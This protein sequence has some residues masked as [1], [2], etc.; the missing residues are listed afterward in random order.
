MNPPFFWG[1]A[2]AAYQT[3]GAALHYGRGPSIWDTFSLKPGN[4]YGNATGLIADDS[5]HKFGEDLQLMKNM[6]LNSYRFFISWSRIYPLGYG[7]INQAGIDHYNKVI[8]ALKDADIEPFVTLYHWDLPQGLEDKYGGWLDPQ[9]ENDFRSYADTCFS[10]FGDRVKKWVTINEPWSIAYQ[11]YGTGL[12]AP[13]RCSNR[14]KCAKGNSATES[15]IAGHNLL[16]AHAAAAELYHTTYQPSQQGEI[17][18]VLNLDWGEPLRPTLSD[19]CAAVK[20]NEFQLAWFADPIFWGRYPARMIAELGTDPTK[21]GRLPVFTETQ[22]ERLIG[23]VDFLGLNHYSTRYYTP[24]KVNTEPDASAGDLGIAGWSPDQHTISSKYDASGKLIGPQADSDWLNTVP[25]GFFNVIMYAHNRYSLAYKV[26]KHGTFGYKS[27]L[28]S[29]DHLSARACETTCACDSATVSG[30]NSGL[31]H[32]DDLQLG[33]LLQVEQDQLQQLQQTDVI[34]NS[35]IHNNNF[36]AS[37]SKRKLR[38]A[39]VPPPTQHAMEEPSFSK[40]TTGL[41]PIPIYITENGCDAP[42]ESEMSIEDTLRDTFRIDY[43]S[44][45]LSQL[46]RAVD[47]G[48]DIKGYFVWS[49]LDNFEW[50]DGFEKRFGLHYV[51]YTTLDRTRYPK[52]SARWYRDYIYKA[53]HNLIPPYKAG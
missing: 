1:A 10:A 7:E 18:I 32:S 42:G 16:N 34:H 31:H 24:V 47:W 46:R 51:D 8:D 22:R 41:L 53:Q 13:G 20:H 11:G 26:H 40:I 28:L 21:G 2:T 19:Y 5:Y 48:V 35:S 15:Y 36:N 33:L 43:L 30:L 37:H 39:L 50:A 6:G 14:K 4:I 45:Y 12:H 25:W 44:R 52:D 38:S 27:R 3:E 23:S 49:L 17:G 29:V 9:I